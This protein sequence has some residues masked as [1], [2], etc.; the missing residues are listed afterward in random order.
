MKFQ[1]ITIWL[2]ILSGVAAQDVSTNQDVLI[3]VLAPGILSKIIAGAIIYNN[4]KEKK[5][6]EEK[7]NS[8]ASRKK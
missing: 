2:L 3:S 6:G 8:I 1:S 4:I 7:L 5:K